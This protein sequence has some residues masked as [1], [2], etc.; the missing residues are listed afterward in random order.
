MVRKHPVVFFRHP[1]IKGSETCFNVDQRDFT[2]V[3]GDRAGRHG[4]RVALDDDG[5][6][7]EVTEQLVECCGTVPDLG[8]SGLA[9]DTDVGV[10]LA[11]RELGEEV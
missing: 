2:G 5:G 7:L 4:V 6:W 3:C 9:T 8:A 11:H 10:W 1:P